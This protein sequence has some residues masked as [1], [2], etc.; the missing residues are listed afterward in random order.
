MKD[1]TTNTYGRLTVES[2]DHVKRYDSANNHQTKAY[3]RC[4]CNCGKTKIVRGE[5]LVSGKITSCGCLA[6]ELS[7]ARTKKLRFKH[8]LSTTATYVSYS[9]MLA[10]V[11]RPDEH[12]KKY[13]SHVSIDDR[14]LGPDGFIHFLEDMGERPDGTELDREDNDGDYTP[15]NCRWVTKSENMRNTRRKK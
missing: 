11:I 15:S 14:W 12:H 4:L 3:W 9:A 1:I 10:R 13:Y 7:S 2:L 5:H 8:G 6:R